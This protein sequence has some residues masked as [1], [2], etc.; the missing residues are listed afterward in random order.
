MAA[1]CHEPEKLDDRGLDPYDLRDPDLR[2]RRVFRDRILGGGS[3][4]SM[5]FRRIGLD[6]RLR[7][8]FRFRQFGLRRLG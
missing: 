8:G 1:E 5:G 3:G 6:R 7:L 2:V 4:R